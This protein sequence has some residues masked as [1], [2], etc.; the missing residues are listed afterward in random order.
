MRF[1]DKIRAIASLEPRLEFVAKEGVIYKYTHP[2]P[3]GDIRL[4]YKR[5]G[6]KYYCCCVCWSPD[7]N[8]DQMLAEFQN[9]IECATEALDRIENED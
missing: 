8:E 5:Q 4:E 3:D 1:E 6:K 2:R 9:M 7:K